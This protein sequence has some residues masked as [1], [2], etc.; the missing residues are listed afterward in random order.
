MSIDPTK[1]RVEREF[2]HG[3]PLVGCRFDPTGRFLFAGA[4]DSTIQRFDLVAGTA[5]TLAGHAS[6]VRGLAFVSSQSA[7]D[8]VRSAARR[9]V[10][11]NTVVGPA[12]QAVAGP[13]SALAP[14]RPP[15]PFTLISADYHGKLIWWQGDAAEPKPIR[16][17][18]AHDGWARA[19]AVSPDGKLV[20]SCGNDNAVR[21]WSAADGKP[22]RTLEGHTSHVYNVA[23][24]PD[25]KHVASADL[26]GIIKDWDVK[27]G[28][29]IRDL[30]A[31]IL[32]KYD[33][34]FLAD[35][36]GARGMAFDPSTGRLACSGITNVSNAFAGVGNPIVILFDWKEGKPKQLKPKDAF[37]GTA[38]GVAF[39]PD[40]YIIAAGGGSG[41]RVWFWKGEEPAS[42]HMITLKTSGRDLALHPSGESF[43]VAGSNGTATIY[44]FTPGPAP[45]EKKPSKKK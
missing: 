3:S 31:K 14:S 40:G 7:V 19:V 12:M 39:H 36:G 37:Q 1:A 27:T 5:T 30:D 2:K 23:F 35:I 25:G 4:Q 26:K 9:T 8:A 24:H 21:I 6:W 43:A 16:T 42:M 32:N 38:W 28:R 15:Q 13:A 41:G 45:A 22:V 20:A 11:L 17:V 10:L 34:T 18:A 44:T 33:T 29:C